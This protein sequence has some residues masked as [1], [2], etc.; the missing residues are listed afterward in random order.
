MGYLDPEYLGNRRL[1]EKMDVYA[2][3]ILILEVI[4]GKR[5]YGSSFEDDKLSLVDWAWELQENDRFLEMVDPKLDYFPADEVINFINVAL[6][7][8]QVPSSLR[9]SMF[10]VLLMLSGHYNF[11]EEVPRKPTHGDIPSFLSHRWSSSEDSAS[12]ELTSIKEHLERREISQGKGVQSFRAASADSILSVHEYGKGQGSGVA[13]DE[14]IQ[15]HSSKVVEGEGRTTS[16]GKT[17]IDLISFEGES[18]SL[19]FTMAEDLQMEYDPTA[20]S[21]RSVQPNTEST[22]AAGCRPN[23]EPMRPEAVASSSMKSNI[24]SA[25]KADDRI[26]FETE[27]QSRS[28]VL[29]LQ[30]V[31]T[32]QS[33]ESSVQEILGAFQE[34]QV[35]TVGVYGKG[36]IGKTTVLKALFDH[37]ETKN[38]FNLVIWV[39][40]SRNSSRRKIQ[41]Q[42]LQQL[43]LQ[44]NSNSE[45]EI[46]RVVLNHLNGKKVLLLLDD[47]WE[48]INLHEIGIPDPAQEN[49]WRL[50]LASR[51]VDICLRMADRGFEVKALSTVE[52]W[53]LF[54]CQAGEVVD[55]PEIHPY[56]QLIPELC[57][58]LPLLVLVCGQ[59]LRMESDV[60]EWKRALKKFILPAA[61]NNGQ[62]ASPQLKFCYDRLKAWDVKSCFLYSALFPEGEMIDVSKV[63]ECFVDEGLLAGTIETA[64]KRGP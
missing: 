48:L 50:V 18:Q 27:G 58:G 17:E 36:G 16:L 55:F 47:V 32:N 37:P 41:D 30:K 2:F 28:E 34:V 39:T 61:V 60:L 8:V 21:E 14:A 54:R 64:L 63:V 38:L 7:C 26:I 44:V 35:R 19:H 15:S 1:T 22:A 20:Y 24:Q 6:F 5:N 4:G 52:A 25:K 49:G 59:T 29:S 40:M 56:A 12:A 11:S 57:G 45:D 10:K 42:I 33:I 9:P 31:N 23:D 43:S 46:A 13:G 51:H 53:E 3:G 62:Y